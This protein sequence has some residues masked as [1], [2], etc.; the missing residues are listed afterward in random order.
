MPAMSKKRLKLSE[1]IRRAVDGCGV[2]R[3]RVCKAARIDQAALSRF[4]A[5]TVGMSQEKLDALADVL[6]LNVTACGPVRVPPMEKAGR[7][8]KG[9][10]KL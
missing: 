7:K 1:Q 4:M 9:G 3:Y 8:P 2:S 10:R 6:R 5:G